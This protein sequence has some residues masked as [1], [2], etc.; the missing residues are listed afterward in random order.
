MPNPRR[1]SGLDLYKRDL[2]TSRDLLQDPTIDPCIWP[3][4]RKPKYAEMPIC[5]EH[6]YVV[7]RHIDAVL[8]EGIDAMPKKQ[9]SQLVYYLMVGP[10]T[11]KIGT[12]GDLL[13]R[14]GQLRTDLQYIVA[15]E[16]GTFE[17]EAER[18]RQFDAERVGKRED[19]IISDRLT[20][21]IRM[22]QSETYSDELLEM[23]RSQAAKRPMLPY[24]RR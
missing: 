8:L 16:Q 14:I 4:C 10:Q 18:H 5:F 7:H 15:V 3:G 6:A 9:K 24:S 23:Y 13:Q 17:L 2:T 20:N 22:I 19:F 11:V 12:T 1:S 21:H